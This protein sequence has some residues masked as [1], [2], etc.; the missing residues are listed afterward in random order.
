MTCPQCN[1]KKLKVKHAKA[2]GNLFVACT[3]FPN[4]K[5]TMRMPKGISNLRM[6]E[7]QCPNC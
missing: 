4:C 1:T 3:Y 5:N 7:K 6:L 2:N